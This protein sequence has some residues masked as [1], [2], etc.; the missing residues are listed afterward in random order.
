[1]HGC[2][3]NSPAIVHACILELLA[4]LS[5]PLQV[6][7]P[8]SPLISFLR[9]VLL[10]IIF[11]SVLGFV[12]T[13]VTALLRRLTSRCFFASSLCLRAF[14]SDTYTDCVSRHM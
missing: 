9:C 1:M 13:L 10:F 2:V 7:G 8:G 5:F 4:Q 3:F 12:T 6:A 14:C 11:F